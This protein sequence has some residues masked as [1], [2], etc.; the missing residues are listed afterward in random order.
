MLGMMGMGGIP[1]RGLSSA[2][3]TVP[4]STKEGI[5]SDALKLVRDSD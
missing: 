5:H 1:W 3:S 4:R 2:S